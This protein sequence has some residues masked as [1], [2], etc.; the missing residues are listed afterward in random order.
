LNIIRQ[1][2]ES[3][4]QIE[5]IQQGDIEQPAAAGGTASCASNQLF[6][7]LHTTRKPRVHFP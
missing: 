2:V 5:R 4:S 7:P 6:V 3:A 1:Q